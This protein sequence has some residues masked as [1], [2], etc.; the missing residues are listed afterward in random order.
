MLIYSALVAGSTVG[1]ALLSKLLAGTIG[2][3][4]KKTDDASMKLYKNVSGLALVAISAFLAPKFLGQDKAKALTGGLLTA[5]ALNLAKNSF[6]F[7]AFSGVS[8][9]GNS[10]I[11]DKTFFEG[12]DI[13]GVFEGFY[14]QPVTD[15]EDMI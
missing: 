14:D 12:D 11:T 4:M 13:S 7:D 1:G 2:G 6:G 9:P 8:L 5:L 15:I 3:L 10:M